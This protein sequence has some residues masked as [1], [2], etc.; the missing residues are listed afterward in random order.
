VNENKQSLFGDMHLKT[1]LGLSFGVMLLLLVLTAAITIYEVDDIQTVSDRVAKLRTPEAVAGLSLLNGMNQSLSGLRAWMLLGDPKFKEV[2]HRA[3]NEWIDPNLELM[4]RLTE[5]SHDKEDE[6]RLKIIKEDLIKLRELELQIEE[7]AHT[8]RENPSLTM[9]NNVAEPLANKMAK[10]ITDIIDI[11][12]QQPG[13]DLRKAMLYMMADIRG[14][15]GLGLASIRSFIYTGDEK[16]RRTFENLWSKNSKRFADL[17]RSYKHLTPEQKN[18]FNQFRTARDEF[19][20]LPSKMFKLRSAKDW[21]LA[22]HLLATKA[23]PFADE[24]ESLLIKTVEHQTELLAED[25]DHVHDLVTE[26]DT[27][28]LILLGIGVVVTMI[29][30]YVV[31]RVIVAPIIN[32]AEAVRYIAANQDMTISVPV[33]GR[34]EIGQMSEAFNNMIDVLRKAFESVNNSA[35]EVSGGAVDVAQRAGANRKRAQGE[36]ERSRTSEK[37]ITEMGNTAGQVSVA[38]TGQQQA[39]EVSQK[40]IVDLLEKI[41]GV[42]KTAK[43]QDNEVASALGTVGAM[44]ETGA[45]VVANAQDQGKMVV[46]VTESMSEMSSAV[47]EMQKAVAQATEFG[48]ASL[49]AADEGRV[50]VD[51]S[52]EG[53]RAIADSSDQISEIIGV[54]TEIAE[55]TNLLALNAAVEAAR[56]GAHGKGFAVVADEVGKLAQRSSEAAKEITQLIKESTSNVTDGVKL[57]DQL[58]DALVKIDEGGKLNIKAI[59]AISQTSATLAINTSDAQ[60]LIAE[61]NTL[62]QQIREMA[63]EQGARRKDAEAALTKLQEYSKLIVGLVD[64]SNQEAKQVSDEMGGVI[65]RGKEMTKMTE[66]QTQRSK[67]ITKLSTE[68]AQAAAQTVEGAGNVVKVTEALEEQ[69]QNLTEQI[70]Q[71]KF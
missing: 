36:M 25:T 61:L 6:R 13:T 57:S 71:F 43:D 10:L 56:A 28:V 52:A 68:S 29:I 11:E 32:V 9:L 42:S 66:M 27:F 2:S 60:K 70:S 12:G 40:A 59:D 45:K 3:W 50:S 54:I 64:E 55:Q 16:F 41:D 49:K 5:E 8:E 31:G 33:S 58:Q 44:G 39:A 46:R 47:D 17:S 30:L 37:V 20:D 67:A 26:L 22:N 24:V 53:M 63:G 15:T 1:K 14:T 48:N 62:A 4:E 7:I 23:A 18:L 35:Q 38:V 34:D 21:N 19:N 51:A 69:S 65:K